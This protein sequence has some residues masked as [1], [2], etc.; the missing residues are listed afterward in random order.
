M[1][2]RWLGA[3]GKSESLDQSLKFELSRATTDEVACEKIIKNSSK[4]KHAR[5]GLMIASENAIKHF[6]GDCWSVKTENGNLVKTRNPKTA[7]GEHLETWAN[8]IYNKIVVK[9]Y[10]DLKQETKKTLAYFSRK[11][12]LEIVK[13]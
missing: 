12:N 11:Y 2:V 1:L 13:M 8:P 3:F 4:I 9:Q 5:I 10:D 7:N 6:K